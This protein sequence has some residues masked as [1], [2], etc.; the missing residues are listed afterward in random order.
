MGYVQA[1]INQPF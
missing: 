1:D